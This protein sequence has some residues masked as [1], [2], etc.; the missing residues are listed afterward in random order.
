MYQSVQNY[1]YELLIERTF[2]QL[3]NYTDFRSL[4]QTH[5]CRADRYYKTILLKRWILAKQ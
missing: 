1:Y 5:K 3:L 2:K 4:K